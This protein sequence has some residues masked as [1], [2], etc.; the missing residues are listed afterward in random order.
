MTGATPVSD[1][2]FIETW[3]GSF[4]AVSTPQIARVGAFFSIFRDLQDLHSFAPL[5]I[6]NFCKISS[7]FFIDVL[8]FLK[9]KY[10]FRIKIIVFQ[11]NF[12][13]I[14]SGFHEI[15]NILVKLS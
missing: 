15:P 1:P 4:S 13:E 5:R 7:N 6:Q 12:D 11:A 14:L 9:E 8:H 3:E 10:R 2:H